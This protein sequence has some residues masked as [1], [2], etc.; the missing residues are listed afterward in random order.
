MRP[1]IIFGRFLLRLGKFIQSLSVMVMRPDDLIEHMR[2]SYAEPKNVEVWSKNSLVDSGL[3]E[4]ETIV[5]KKIPLKKGRLLLLGIGGGREAIPLG[6]MGFDITGV[7][8]APDLVKSAIQNTAQKGINIEG[9]IQD[10]TELN[11]S[12]NTYDIAWLSAGMYSCIPTRKKRIKM[13]KRVNASLK[14]DG[15]FACQYLWTPRH[16]FSL[17]VEFARKA[18]AF[19]T[20][21]NMSYEKGDVMW[22]DS[23]FVHLFR[24]EEE[25]RS[26]FEEGGFEVVHIDF[27]E[28]EVR[29]WAV[30]RKPVPNTRKN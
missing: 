23:H 7:D 16:M 27:P 9:I 25:I 30:L 6:K 29:R 14:Q 26:E 19:L 17:K 15:Y 18:F 11:V 22:D 13:V 20:L 5:L 28:G 2:N 4:D 10:I 3:H 1:R 21:G 24:S 12:E 8:F